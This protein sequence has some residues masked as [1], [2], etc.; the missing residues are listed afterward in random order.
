M[1]H[2]GVGTKTFG[3]IQADGIIRIGSIAGTPKIAA[4]SKDIMDVLGNLT[5]PDRRIVTKHTTDMAIKTIALAIQ[6]IQLL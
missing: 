2:L 3:Y 6:R 1:V 4:D 5:L